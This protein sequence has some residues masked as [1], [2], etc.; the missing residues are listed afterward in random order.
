MA[1]LIHSILEKIRAEN[2]LPEVHFMGSSNT[3]V[4]EY[5]K[6]FGA[7]DHEYFKLKNY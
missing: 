1:L 2:I 4:A 3:G 6:K 5:N 7:V